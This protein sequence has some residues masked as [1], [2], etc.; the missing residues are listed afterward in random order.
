MM[1]WVR[2]EAVVGVNW[3]GSQFLLVFIK[4]TQELTRRAI[5]NQ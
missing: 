1:A 5:A 4:A 3:M 2:F